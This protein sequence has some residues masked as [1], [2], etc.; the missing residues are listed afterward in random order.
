MRS[1]PAS[2]IRAWVRTSL[3]DPKRSR[4][5][6]AITTQ[7]SLGGFFVP[8][9]YLEEQLGELADV[10]AIETGDATWEL[11]EVL[12]ER[13]DVYGG[14]MRVWWPGLTLDADWRDHK[15]FLIHSEEEGRVKVAQLL[16]QLRRRAGLDSP[17]R[18]RPE[19]DASRGPSTTKP[20]AMQR[21]KVSVLSLDD[22][23][24]LQEPDGALG[25]LVEADAPV[26]A[27][28]VCLREGM[29][30][31]VDRPVDHDFAFGEAPCSLTGLL[32]KAWEQ[33]GAELF[34]GDVVRGRVVRIFEEQNYALIDLLPNAAGIVFKPEVDVTFVETIG[35]LITIDELV[36]VQLLELEAPEERT[37]LSIR[38]ALTTSSSPRPSPTLVP[39]GE[40]FDWKKYLART[41]VE[42]TTTAN[43]RDA[44]IAELE[45]ELDAASEDRT[46]LRRT[47]NGLRA[48][49][50][51]LQDRYQ[52]LE[53]SIAGELDPLSD[54]RAF[55]R[56]VRGWYAREI[57]EGERF[58][59]PLRSMRVGRQF[60]DSARALD[61]VGADKIVEVA[62]QVAC[63]RAKD[64][65]SREV[66]GLGVS[67]P[68][69][70]SK[71]RLRARDGAR[72]WRC[73]LQTNT[74]SARRLHWWQV[75]GPS[76]GTIEFASVA[77]HDVFDIP[78]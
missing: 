56:A 41:G 64:L 66:H 15:L 58:E 67:G 63:D 11:A 25:R 78:E 53:R 47:L 43:P 28:A 42:F 37:K 29:E 12:P 9:A 7:P 2:E 3:L 17:R 35:D 62:G 45:S 27:V 73:A 51:S 19:S 74:P 5:V 34:V 16:G 68:A 14:A 1:I 76:G 36:Q 38:A 50:R 48:E 20:P 70:A 22:G 54:E 52:N 40:P 39:G 24:L 23:V 69:T 26:D 30:L 18:P 55:L 8:P 49:L 10:V 72:A 6:V 71:Q 46:E 44:R 13:L 33:I 60:L 57:G 32:P 75:P 59:H 31:A 77:V 4:P 61:G 65:E 21:V